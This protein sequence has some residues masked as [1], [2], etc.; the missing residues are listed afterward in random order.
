MIKQMLGKLKDTSKTD[1]GMITNG[2]TGPDMSPK[3]LGQPEEKE[4]K[5]RRA[6]EK[7]SMGKIVEST[8]SPDPKIGLPN[9]PTRPR[10]VLLLPQYSL[11]TT[12]TS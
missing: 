11:L 4:R 10:A 2:M 1:N 5:E 7:T 12:V 3:K 8:G 6:K 9:L